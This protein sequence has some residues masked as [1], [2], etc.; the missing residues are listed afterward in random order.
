MADALTFAADFPA[1]TRDAWLRAVRGVILKSKPDAPDDE[2]TAAFDATAGHPDRGRHRDPAAVHRRGPAA[3]VRVARVRAVRPLVARRADT[4][5]DPPARV[6][7]RRRVERARRARVRGDRRAA[8]A[9]RRRVRR[10]RWKRRST[11]CCSTSR[12]CRWRRRRTTTAPL[13]PR[14]LLQLWSARDVAPAVA[15]RHPRRRPG[16]RVGPQRRRERPRRRVR[17][18]CRRSSA[19]RPSR[20]RTRTCSWSTAPCGTTPAPPT[21]R[22]SAWAIAA[23]AATVRALA[24]RGVDGRDGVP[25]RRAAPRGHRGPVRHD[26]QDP[27]SAA[28]VGPRRRAGGP[29]A[30][31]PSGPGPRR[32]VTGDD[33]PLRPVGERAALDRG[34]LLGRS[35]RRATR[36]RSTRTTRCASTAVPRSAGGSRATP[37]PSCRWRATS[38]A[39]STPPVDRGTSSSGPTTSL[40]SRGRRC[41]RSRPPA[42]IVAAVRAGTVHAALDAV[43][44]ERRSQLATRKR[45]I[46]GVSEFPDIS[47]APPA[48]VAV[49]PAAS[50]TP[51]APFVLAP[52]R[53]RVRGAARSRRCARDR[54]RHAPDDLPRH[55]RAGCGAHHARRRSPRTCSRRRGSA[56]CRA[57]STRS[58]RS[59]ADGRVPVLVRRGVRRRGCRGGRRA[60]RGRRRRGSTS[61]AARSAST[62]WTRRSGWVRTC[63]TRSRERS[64]NWG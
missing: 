53:R 35:G 64:T 51:F 42:G 44:A 25:P 58:H 32:G 31:G 63:S 23:G 16:R 45:P 54:H 7:R 2:F 46:T 56:P 52:H 59:G 14:L 15:A 57:R 28:P 48:Q 47:E 29:A 22:S 60:A 55:A 13:R 26:R 4:L 49:A 43:A 10:R 11:A 27:R 18:R 38:R 20:R 19:T 17:R 30:G 1:A 61:P 34:V 39:S 50:G 12:R 3:G 33:D 9:R 36:S 41:S 6:D 5:G 37:R 62:V 8:R 21:R 40:A 24:D